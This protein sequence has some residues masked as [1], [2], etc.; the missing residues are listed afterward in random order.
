[1]T[2][3]VFV[4]PGIHLKQISKKK[5]T[6]MIIIQ[7]VEYQTK[8]LENN[9]TFTRIKILYNL[10]RIRNVTAWFVSV[11]PQMQ[12]TP[13]YLSKL[14]RY[15]NFPVRSGLT[16]IVRRTLTEKCQRRLVLP[17]HRS[18]ENRRH[19]QIAEQ[20]SFGPESMGHTKN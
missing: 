6:G 5:K 13:R 20:L 8:I 3:N 17:L 1:M 14:L 2:V 11:K 12:R 10:L 16:K 4:R 7:W 15:Q 19:E 18:F 9:G